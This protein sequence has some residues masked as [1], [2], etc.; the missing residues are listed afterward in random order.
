MYTP[1]G[2]DRGIRSDTV[3][4]RRSKIWIFVISC[5]LDSPGHAKAIIPR[6]ELFVPFAMQRYPVGAPVGSRATIPGG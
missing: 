3:I 1:Y 6:G 2:G 4:H 5:R